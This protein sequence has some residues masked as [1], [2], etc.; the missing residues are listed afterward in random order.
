MSRDPYDESVVTPQRI[1]QLSFVFMVPIFAYLGYLLFDDLLF[2]GIVGL[3]VGGGQYLYLPYFMYRG[4]AERGDVSNL[5]GGYV[6]RAA[7]GIG[8]AGGGMVA[9]AARFVVEGAT[10][11]PLVA[12]AVFALLASVPLDYALPSVDEVGPDG[13]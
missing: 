10:L 4:A 5:D 2:G 11:T 3:I 9:L 8:L 1:A 13:V 6:R 7:A 12:G